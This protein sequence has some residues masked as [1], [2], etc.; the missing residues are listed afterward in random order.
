MPGGRPV[1]DAPGSGRGTACDTVGTARSAGRAV[2]EGDAH[3]PG[4]LLLENI[5]TV[6]ADVL[7]AAG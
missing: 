3:V 1:A 4:A 2:S 5:D 7:R 6:A